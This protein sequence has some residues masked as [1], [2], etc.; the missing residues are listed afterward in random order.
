MRIGELAAQAEVNVQTVRFYEREGLLPRPIRTPSGYR[1][2]QPRDTERVKFIKVCQGLGFTLREVRQL[3]QL[4]GVAM[5][6]LQG[7]AVTNRNS[8]KILIIARDRLA[9]IEEKIAQLSRMREEMQGVIDSLSSSK[10]PRCPAASAVTRLGS[11]SQCD[12]F[13]ICDGKTLEV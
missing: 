3:I 5:P 10:P 2:Y 7:P 12:A 4:H 1:S 9:S 13:N 6:L 8:E 11:M